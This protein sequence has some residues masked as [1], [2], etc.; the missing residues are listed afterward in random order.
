MEKALT[1]VHEKT[2]RGSKKPN[3][4]AWLCGE[5]TTVE[6][7]FL[8]QKLARHLGGRHIDHQLKRLDTRPVSFQ[9]AFQVIINPT[10]MRWMP[11][12]LHRYF[13]WFH[14]S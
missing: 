14:T 3:K 12:R 1:H 5:Q 2:S 7:G 11:L 4:M 8:L 9:R 6:E 13:W 10:F